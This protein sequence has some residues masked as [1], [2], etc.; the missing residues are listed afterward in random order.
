M[1]RTSFLLQFALIVALGC[2]PAGA[3]TSASL[4]RIEGTSLAGTQ[5]VLPDAANGKIAVL[6]F[7]FSHASK[8]A[9]S[10]WADKLY[11]DFGSR[12]DF[13]VYQ[14]PVLAGAPS[15]VRGMIV[16][17]M[18]KGM[19]ETRRGYFIPLVKG[20]GELKNLVGFKE[21]DDA[22][23]LTLDASGHIAHQGH[24]PFRDGDYAALRA[25]LEV[26]LKKK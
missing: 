24:G 18:K 10:A 2:A 25:E 12:P 20:E 11:A 16:S 6:I 26:M 9:I 23:L 15:W 14:L 8:N 3:Q 22:Y 17:S 1:R 21:A 13:A 5:V 7:G 4:P 19:P